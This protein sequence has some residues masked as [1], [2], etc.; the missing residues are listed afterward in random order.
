MSY[1]LGLILSFILL[2][3]YV[4]L[5]ILIFLS[6]II[7][8]I[9]SNAM[10]IVV[11]VFC[12]QS[13]LD[14]TT[15]LIV[16]F[17]ASVLGD[18]CG[19]YLTWRYGQK[20]W[21]KFAKKPTKSLDLVKKYLHKYASWTIIISRFSNAVGIIVNLFCGFSKLSFKK[22]ILADIAGNFLNVLAML[23]I[24]YIVGEYWDEAA[25]VVNWIGTGLAIALVLFAA[26]KIWSWRR[27]RVND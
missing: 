8:P 25:S 7:L 23:L 19:Y 6:A 22:F 11:G 1:T 21:D 17:T 24:G 13:Y 10:E 12:N 4:A 20:A 9:P 5:F 27:N 16:S 3:K 26:Y 14:F 15:S 2:Y 18:S